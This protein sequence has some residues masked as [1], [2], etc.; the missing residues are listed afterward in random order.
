MTCFDSGENLVWATLNY[1]RANPHRASRLR[2]A[3]F[4]D[5]HGNCVAFDGVLSDIQRQSVDGMVCLGDAIQ[6]GAQ[7]TEVV[8]RLRELH[9]PTV[10]GNADYW[11]ITGTANT[12]KEP[13]SNVQLEVRAWSLS[14][15]KK[16]DVDFIGQFKP[17]ITLPFGDGNLVCFH[18]SPVSFDQQ[19]W[20]TTPE[21]EF[22]RMVGGYGNSV[23]C[24]GHVHLQ[25]MRRFKDSFFFNP[26]SVGFSW[27]HVQTGDELAADSWAEYAIVTSDGRTSSL[28]FRKVPFDAEEWIRVTADSGKPHAD[29]VSREYSART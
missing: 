18:G 15:L 8:S 3:V 2:V 25:Y 7:P 28:E 23:L 6:G 27:N 26:G 1:I 22:L 10:M 29:R 20:P 17:V 12:A 24:G 13:V 21:E 5:I 16:E 4:S 9:I 11:L 19:I 14:K